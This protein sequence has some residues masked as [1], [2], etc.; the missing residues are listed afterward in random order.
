M[1]NTVTVR[2]DMIIVGT[3]QD[4]WK[5]TADDIFAL[6]DGKEIPIAEE[7]EEIQ[8]NIKA[9]EIQSP[10]KRKGIWLEEGVD[11]RCSECGFECSDPHY[12]GKAKFCPEC[13]T[14]MKWGRTRCQEE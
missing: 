13:G 11:I 6:R 1:K 12:L 2:E 14:E 9:L 10:I 7:M 5:F 3:E 8:K 4:G